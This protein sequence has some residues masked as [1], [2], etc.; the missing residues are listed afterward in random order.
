MALLVSDKRNDAEGTLAQIGKLSPAPS[1]NEIE[2]I[3]AG[4]RKVSDN[5][6][7]PIERLEDLL[8]ILPS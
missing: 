6:P 8:G 7:Q 3:S 5:L 1:P 2:S 4:F